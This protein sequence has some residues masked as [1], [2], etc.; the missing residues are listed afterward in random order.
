[1]IWA[2]RTLMAEARE[3]YRHLLRAIS[4]H[5]SKKGSSAKCPWKEYVSAEF[6]RHASEHDPAKAQWLVQLAKDYTF[7]ANS[8]KEHRVRSQARLFSELTRTYQQVSKAKQSLR[9]AQELLLSYN[10]GIDRDARQ[11]QSVE[12]T[13]AAVG[14]QLPKKP[15][16]ED[17]G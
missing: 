17:G 15:W 4:N 16:Q 13:A 6:R 2:L 14:M 5:I 7:L 9:L 11:M 12:R 1:M 8:V 3:A 10:I